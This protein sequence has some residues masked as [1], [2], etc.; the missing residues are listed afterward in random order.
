MNLMRKLFDIAF[1]IIILL[2]AVTPAAAQTTLD[3]RVELRGTIADE[4]GAVVL[5]T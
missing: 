3:L 5:T 4:A 2:A 1:P